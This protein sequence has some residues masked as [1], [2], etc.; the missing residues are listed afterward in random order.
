MK[1][2]LH[3]VLAIVAGCGSAAPRS[4]TATSMAADPQTSSSASAHEPG[5][6]VGPTNRAAIEAEV[7][8]WTESVASSAPTDDGVRSL[9]AARAG[10]S[11]T[12]YLGTWCG[13]SRREVTRLWAALDRLTDVPF[14]V[15]YV[16]VDRAKTAPGNV[17]D[18]VGLERVPTFI[19]TRD[20]AE[21]GRVV[22]SAP[23]GI[24]SDL[25]ALLSGTRTGVISGRTDL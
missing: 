7:P 24:E 1:T 10:G 18:G 2:A 16:G 5:V 6:L 21:V 23:D 14:D 25:A 4:E 3:V 11:V 12:I 8:A 19:V 15:A 17:L 20:G 9:G 22:E 13:D